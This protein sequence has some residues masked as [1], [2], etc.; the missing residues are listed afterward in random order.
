LIDGE[1]VEMVPIGSL[2][3]AV[4]DTLISLLIRGLTREQAIVRTQ[5]PIH[6]DDSSEPQPDVTLV[7]PRRDFY[8]AAHPQA[9]DVLLLIEVSDSTLAFDRLVKLPLYA[10]A[11]IPEVWIVDLASGTIE[12]NRGPSA[13]GYA[14]Q[15]VAVRGASVS[16]AGF[17]KLRLPVEAIL[18]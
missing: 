12:V 6:L 4:V 17:P 3:A 16:P 7:K 9:E 13:G 2:H 5:N 15:T 11:G 18:G 14:S 10:Q 1:I 8:R